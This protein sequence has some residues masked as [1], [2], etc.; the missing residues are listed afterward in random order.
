MY[1]ANPTIIHHYFLFEGLFICVLA[2]W[3]PVV[4]LWNK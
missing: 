4:G 3:S 2:L 1:V